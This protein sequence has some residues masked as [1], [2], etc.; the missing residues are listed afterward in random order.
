MTD[1]TA[2]EFDPAPTSGNEQ[3]EPAPPRRRGP[4]WWGVVLF[5]ALLGG[6]MLVNQ[7][8]TTGGPPVQWFTGDL[9]AAL[10]QISDQKPRVFLY[11]YE[12]GQQTHERNELQV[13]QQRW[14]RYP[15]ENAICLRVALGHDMASQNLRQRFDYKGQPLF[16]LL[17]RSG[18][19][20]GRTEGAVD[21]RQFSTYIGKPILKALGKAGEGDEP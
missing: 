10:G 5:L 2:P 8:A 15:L 1:S 11:L 9:D 14:A 18:Q 3:I 7:W 19:P 16:L 4:P 13:F 21:E 17:N 6:W 20:V 12:P